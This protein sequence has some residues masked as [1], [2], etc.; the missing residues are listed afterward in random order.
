MPSLASSTH[1]H[2]SVHKLL[3]HTSAPGCTCPY[4]TCI[5]CDAQ[6]SARCQL[7]TT[8]IGARPPQRTHAAAAQAAPALRSAP[9]ARLLPAL[10]ALPSVSASERPGPL[11]QWR[12]RMHVKGN[13]LLHREP[14]GSSQ[15]ALPGLLGG[16]Q[17]TCFVHLQ[18]RLCMLWPFSSGLAPARMTTI[19][20]SWPA[21]R[22]GALL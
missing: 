2:A 14:S 9:S 1:L 10:P 8:P 22:I 16:M 11:G 12:E 20:H 18:S 4:L 3:T 7:C 17:P 19:E 13:L 6:A 21:A 15:R 5:P